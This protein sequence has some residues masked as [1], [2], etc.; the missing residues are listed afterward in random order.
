MAGLG[1][2]TSCEY[3]FIEPEPVIL[4]DVISFADDI[5]PIF[6]NSCN[7]SGC[8]VSG[9][10]VLDLSAENAYNDLFRKEQIDVDNPEASTLYV[11]LIESG[12]THSGR[13]T[14]TE[15][16]TILEWIRKGAQNN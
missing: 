6:D 12:G 14:A 11:K 8:H 1:M 7:F 16:A 2:F 9:F 13:S 10:G 3:E 4:P 15:R 5:I